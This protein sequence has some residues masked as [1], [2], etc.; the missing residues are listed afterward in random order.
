MCSY[1]K[2]IDYSCFKNIYFAF[3]QSCLNTEMFDDMMID[4][5]S[6]IYTVDGTFII[7]GLRTVV[8][9]LEWGGGLSLIFNLKSS[10]SK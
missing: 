5:M 7:V 3:C 10:T 6:F 2:N 1:N 9:F 8:K 4:L